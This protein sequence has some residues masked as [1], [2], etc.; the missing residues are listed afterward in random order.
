MV[1]SLQQKKDL[2]LS[3]I[4][5]SKADKI[6]VQLVDQVRLVS[7]INGFFFSDLSVL[8]SFLTLKCN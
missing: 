6:I 3:T 1:L 7:L 8:F 5:L 4:L 2:F